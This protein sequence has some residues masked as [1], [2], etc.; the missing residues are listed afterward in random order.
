MCCHAIDIV[1]LTEGFKKD[2][3]IVLPKPIIDADDPYNIMIK[4]YNGNLGP[5]KIILRY[6]KN[7]DKLKNLNDILREKENKN[8]C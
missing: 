5:K 4:H 7:N 2:C 8:I 3:D 1:M 6:K